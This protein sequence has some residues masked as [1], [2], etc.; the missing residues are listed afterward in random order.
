MKLKEM[1][2][3][4]RCKLKEAS[5]EDRPKSD[6]FLTKICQ[7]EGIKTNRVQLNKMACFDYSD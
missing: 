6:F 4:S 1:K 3:R 2:R 7:I 5:E